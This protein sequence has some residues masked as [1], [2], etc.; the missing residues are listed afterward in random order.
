M[1]IYKRCCCSSKK[2]S[3]CSSKELNKLSS[4]LSVI[5][6]KTRLEILYLLKYKP[7]CVCD[8]EAHTGMSQ[9]LISHHLADLE[10]SH[11][12]KSKREGKFVDYFL[13]TKGAKT[14][15]ALDS[16]LEK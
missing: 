13:T 3:C 5:S 7:H 12:I 9:S 6:V 11:L 10:N 15:R 1:F 16:L 8:I 2:S 4:D 14:V